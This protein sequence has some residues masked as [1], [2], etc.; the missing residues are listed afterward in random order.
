MSNEKKT[1]DNKGSNSKS[2]ETLLVLIPLIPLAIIVIFG[3]FL[4][5]YKYSE[6]LVLTGLI[7][8]IISFIYFLFLHFK[9]E[10]LKEE[11]THNWANIP[12]DYDNNKSRTFLTIWMVTAGLAIIILFGL[13]VFTNARDVKDAK[14][15]FNGT[16]PL[17]A[18]WI[19][20]ILAFYFQKENLEAATN[21]VLALSKENLNKVKVENIMI[22]VQTMVAQ[23][24]DQ[25]EDDNVNLHE[26]LAKYKD[27]EKD[28][29]PIFF[30]N[31]SPRLILHTSTINEFIKDQYKNQAEA[32]KLTLKDLTD[33]YP[34]KFAYRKPKGF[35]TI[36]K[37]STVEMAMN[38][39]GRVNNCQDV[40]I[41]DTGTENGKILG[42]L[43]NVLINRFLTV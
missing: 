21:Q 37:N 16:I 24:I 22:N 17:I 39:M 7:C 30:K 1:K 10:K 2:T 43:T 12:N 14:W 41:T 3:T 26:L 4:N 35:V 25:K 15:V 31:L 5:S 13:L 36:S 32:E 38:E 11:P 20:T 42:W 9:N 23:K 8:F 27:I 29:I 18:T 28:R 33:K 40:F 34:N 6:Y 19:G